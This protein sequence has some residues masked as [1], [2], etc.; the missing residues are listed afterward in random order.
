MQYVHLLRVLL[1]GAVAVGDDAVYADASEGNVAA[2][3]VAVVA[4]GVC[5]YSCVLLTCAVAVDADVRY[6]VA[7]AS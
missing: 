3:A 4:G 1:I 2:N 7:V 6:D 5:V